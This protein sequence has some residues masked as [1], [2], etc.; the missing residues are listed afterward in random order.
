MPPKK[1]HMPMTSNK[2]DSILPMREV[3]TMT[4]SFFTSAMMATINSTALLDNG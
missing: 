1:K 4:T 3:W 2:L